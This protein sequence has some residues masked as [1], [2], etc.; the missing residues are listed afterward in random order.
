M[1]KPTRSCEITRLVS[2]VNTMIVYWK[3]IAER[4][5]NNAYPNS[6][7]EAFEQVWPKTLAN[8]FLAEMIR[9]AKRLRS[10][11]TEGRNN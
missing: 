6:G 5:F 3:V 7:P 11:P 2:L 4:N 10:L 1:N 8:I 9:T